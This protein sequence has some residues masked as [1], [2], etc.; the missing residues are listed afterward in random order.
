MSE[1]HAATLSQLYHDMKLDDP[2]VASGSRPLRQG[3]SKESA[4]DRQPLT[5]LSAARELASLAFSADLTSLEMALAEIRTLLFTVQEL[6]H[7]AAAGTASVDGSLA[8]LNDK[9]EA[10]Q[11][12][13]G[14]MEARLKAMPTASGMLEAKLE[15]LRE[16]LEAILHDFDVRAK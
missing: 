14:A 16:S 9:V 1:L 11:N 6:R 4:H 5:L 8:T 7:G 2:P 15:E 12:D 10:A 13:L 3:A